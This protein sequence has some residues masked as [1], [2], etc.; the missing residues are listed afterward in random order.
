MQAAIEISKKNK[1]K[2]SYHMQRPIKQLMALFSTETMEIRRY[3]QNAER[4]RK[5]SFFS[6]SVKLSFKTKTE[7]KKKKKTPHK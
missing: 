1:T 4:K 3:I 2:Q 5:P 6:H 7:E